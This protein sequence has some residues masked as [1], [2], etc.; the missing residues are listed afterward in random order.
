MAVVRS[1]RFVDPT[2]PATT[3]PTVLATVPLGRT[4]LVKSIRLVNLT[5]DPQAFDLL[6]GPPPAAGWLFAGATI[7]PRAILTDETWWVAE[8]EDEIVIELENADAVSI[9]VSGAELGA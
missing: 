8:A 4:W 1:K 2:S 9:M 7:G 5:D 6:V 3:D